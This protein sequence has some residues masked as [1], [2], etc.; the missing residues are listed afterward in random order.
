MEKYG[1]IQ[2]LILSFV[3][4]IDAEEELCGRDRSG[5]C[6]TCGTWCWRCWACDGWHN[7]N[8]GTLLCASNKSMKPTVSAVCLVVCT[9]IFVER[10]RRCI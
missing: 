4:A 7:L 8:P 1:T 6:G 9:S 5:T 3:L 2:C 10:Q